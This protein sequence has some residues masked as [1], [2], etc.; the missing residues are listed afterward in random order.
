M[1]PTGVVRAT[2]GDAGGGRRGGE[3]GATHILPGCGVG[4]GLKDNARVYVP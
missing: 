2:L 4:K 3:E 1:R